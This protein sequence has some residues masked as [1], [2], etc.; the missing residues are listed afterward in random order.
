MIVNKGL[1]TIVDD[2]LYL[3]L[4]PRILEATA[5][6]NASSA[7]V[8]TSYYHSAHIDVK[9]INEIFSFINWDKKLLQFWSMDPKMKKYLKCF[10]NHH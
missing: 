10:C 1:I 9:N 6:P 8:E 5:L 7:H 4:D 3:N 2:L